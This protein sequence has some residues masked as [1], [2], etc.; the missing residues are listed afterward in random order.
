MANTSLDRHDRQ[1]LEL[2][3]RDASLSLNEISERVHLSRNAVWRRL[4]RLELSGL[5][6]D[7]VVRLDASRLNLGLTVFIAIRTAQHTAE[8]LASFNAAVAVLP[9]ILGVYRMAGDVDYLLH[10]VVPDM[11]A[12][13]ALYKRLIAAVELNDVSSSFV[14]EEIKNTTQLPLTYV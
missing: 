6:R 8:W 7:R 14:M 3:Q 4:Q 2:L 10:A 13:D 11:P 5:I 9:E 12:Y 1:I